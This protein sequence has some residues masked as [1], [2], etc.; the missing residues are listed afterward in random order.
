MGAQGEAGGGQGG[1]G[2]RELAEAVRG[3]LVVGVSGIDDERIPLLAQEINPPAARPRRCGKRVADTADPRLVD[4]TAGL[5][6][7]YLQD[8]GVVHRVDA[9]PKYERGRG[10]CGGAR[11]EP[12]DELARALR[13]LQRD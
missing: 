1:A 9:P 12:R 11:L 7:E 4:L 3:D 13:R 2:E 6:V 8:P 5:R 10:V